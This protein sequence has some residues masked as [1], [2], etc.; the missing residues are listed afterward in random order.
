[1]SRN[2]RHAESRAGSRTS[3]INDPDANYFSTEVGFGQRKKKNQK[4]RRVR[5][6]KPVETAAAVEIDKVAFGDIFLVIS[7]AA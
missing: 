4:E 2:F 5:K 7:T 6:G 3:S 1:M